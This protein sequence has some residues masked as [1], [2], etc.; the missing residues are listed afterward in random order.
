MGRDHA[1]QETVWRYSEDVPQRARGGAEAG[2]EAVDW[3][4]EETN[5]IRI[6]N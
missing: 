2:S 3:V 6:K 1:V 5:R 4:E